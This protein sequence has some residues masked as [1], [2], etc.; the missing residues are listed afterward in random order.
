[1]VSSLD[2]NETSF[3]WPGSDYTRLTGNDAAKSSQLP[4]GMATPSALEAI[5]ANSTSTEV[6]NNPTGKFPSPQSTYVVYM[7]IS[8]THTCM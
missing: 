8:S 5:P 3:L 1:V 4:L 2:G 7:L 6:N